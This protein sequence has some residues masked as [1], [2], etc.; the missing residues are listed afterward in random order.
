[1]KKLLFITPI[2]LFFL[3]LAMCEKESES[4]PGTIRFV[5]SEPGG[6][7][8]EDPDV[9]AT[10]DSS[11]SEEQD[12][13]LFTIINDTLDAYVGINYICCAPFTSETMISNDSIFITISDTCSIPYQTCYCRCM[14]YYTWDFLFVDFENKEYYF[15]IV[16]YDPREEDPIVFKEGILDLTNI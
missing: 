8:L 2:I 10:R 15:K 9:L 6:C 16:L 11:L 3:F 4:S 5:K 1:M 14:C 12:T 7:N 13:L